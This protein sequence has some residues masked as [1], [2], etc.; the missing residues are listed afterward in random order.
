MLSGSL[1]WGS[2]FLRS[3]FWL[4]FLYACIRT[5]NRCM[6]S[7]LILLAAFQAK[8]NAA[9]LDAVTVN[10]YIHREAT[11]NY[12]RLSAF[13]FHPPQK[14]IS[15]VLEI[16]KRSKRTRP[17][18]TESWLRRDLLIAVLQNGM[19]IAIVDTQ[20]SFCYDHREGVLSKQDIA[21]VNRLVDSMPDDMKGWR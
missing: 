1:C 10:K 15:D 2:R 6:V 17:V 8:G 19:A 5:Y 12:S 14:V 4:A 11:I 20:G 16:V 3:R 18:D 9:G 13:G 21:A 7:A